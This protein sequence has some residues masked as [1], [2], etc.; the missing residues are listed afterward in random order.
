MKTSKNTLVDEVYDLL[1]KGLELSKTD[2]KFYEQH[3]SMPGTNIHSVNTSK[4]LLIM[5]M[6]FIIPRLLAV[7]RL[8]I[9]LKIVSRP[10]MSL[11]L[12]DNYLINAT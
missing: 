3:L 7:A 10:H 5:Q 8:L 12:R 4:H 9:L 11:F 2:Q 1:T 6:R